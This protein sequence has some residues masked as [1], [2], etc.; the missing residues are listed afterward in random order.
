MRHDVGSHSRNRWLVFAPLLIVLFSIPALQPLFSN[1]FTCGFDNVFH[2]WR[3]VQIA[4]LMQSGEWFSRWAPHMVRGYGYPLYLFQSPLSAYGAAVFHFSGFS[5]PVSINLVY[6][7]GLVLSA[8]ATWWLVRDLWGELGGLVAAV[9]MLYAPFHIYVVMYRGSMSESAAWI[10]PPLV[11]W[12]LRRW[13][14]LK[15]RVGLVTAVLSLTLLFFT[16]DVTAY[17][18]LPFFVVW[19]VGLS[20]EVRSRT[21]INADEHR[22]S[23]KFRLQRL[24]SGGLA[25]LLGLGGGAFFWLPAVVERG[26]IQFDRASSAWPF[27]FNNNF[28]PLNQL[29]ALPRNADPWLLNDWPERGLG[30][31]LLVGVLVGIVMGWRLAGEKRWITAVITFIFVS[32]LFIVS[33]F[34]TVL[35]EN[36]GILAVFQFPWRF[37]APATLAAAMLIGGIVNCQLSIVNR[38]WIGL[39]LI[40]LL[41]ILHWGWLYPNHCDV[42]QDATVA[43]MVSWELG[44]GTLGTTAS[45]ELLPVT[46]AQVPREPDVPSPWEARILL[47]DLPDGA[48]IVSAEY[49]ALDATIELSTPD[50]FVVRYRAFDFPGWQVTVNGE[51]VPITPSKPHGLITFPVEN[52]WSTIQVTFTETPLRSIADVI[53]ILSIVTLAVMLIRPSTNLQTGHSRAGGN[54]HES[55]GIDSCLRRNDKVGRVILAALLIAAKIWI[56]DAQVTPLHQSRL[57]ESGELAG[58]D[59]PINFVF[60]NP[61]NPAQIRLLGY[62]AVETAVSANQPLVVTL[63]WQVLTSLDNDYRVG[64]TLVDENGLRWSEDGLRDY[65]WVRNP[66]PTTSWPTDKYVQTSYF[67]D[68]LSGT[69]PGEYALELSLFDQLTFEPLT[70]FDGAGQ[71]I[72]PNMLLETVTLTAPPQPMQ[73]VELDSQTLVDIV[74]DEFTFI[75]GDADRNEAAPGDEVLVTLFLSGAG[76]VE[77]N[78][79][80]VDVAETPALSSVEVS[81]FTTPI[82]LSSSVDGVWRHQQLVRLPAGLEDGRFQWQ[83]SLATGESVQFGELIIDAPDRV[84]DQPPILHEVSETFGEQASL[85]GLNYDAAKLVA[86]ET[87]DVDL[88]W[89]G[90]VEMTE[91]YRVFVHLL[92]PD[93]TIIAQSD[94]IPV[95]WTR[96]TTGWQPGEYLTDTHQLTIPQNAESAQL[97]I[98][99]YLPGGDRLSTS[100]GNDSVLLTIGD[101]MK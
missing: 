52:G 4:E 1:Q 3:S 73:F 93:G 54:P 67:V 19:I 91:S 24:T 59:V 55:Q 87:V 62:D 14:L 83:L 20:W 47:A 29:F 51:S 50:P 18:F 34:S 45:R 41:S 101:E 97:R 5:W 26:S 42:P 9:A 99:M 10:F 31:V 72:G 21:Q 57:T 16:H 75:G 71:P 36:V 53:S 74:F 7:L 49:G 28:L 78:L 48:T 100:G 81:V 82:P 90:R 27:L 11:L 79:E 64:L 15:Q 43:G 70:I 85:V 88:I 68:P 80:L 95:V 65:R 69:P 33:P 22:L 38:Q 35:W 17:A 98:G 13:Q 46:V 60:G 92:A 56:V 58:V 37:L 8:I 77:A 84:F 61:A 94:G 44:T 6:A 86:G 96:P 12:G 40:A 2:L 63:Y 23:L 66:E 30:A 25:L 89:Q 32:Y 39:G 76:Q